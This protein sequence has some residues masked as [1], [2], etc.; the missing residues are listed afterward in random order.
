MA[1]IKNVSKRG[2]E[3]KPGYRQ[4]LRVTPLVEKAFNSLKNK[5]QLKNNSEALNKIA[6]I[7]H[8]LMSDKE[9]MRQ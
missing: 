9:E 2:P 4:E 1:E 7:Y 8:T 6:E 3:K 5:Y